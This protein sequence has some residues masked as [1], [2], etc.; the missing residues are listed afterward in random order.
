MYI[1][2]SEI[3]VHYITL[4]R[5]DYVEHVTNTISC[6]CTCGTYIVN[7]IHMIYK[8]LLRRYIYA[9]VSNVLH[10]QRV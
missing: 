2:C 8:V 9:C 5:V 1:C 6:I 3:V 4:Q 7:Y 10:E